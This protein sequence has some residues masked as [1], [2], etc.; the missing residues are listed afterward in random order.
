MEMLPNCEPPANLFRTAIADVFRG[1][2]FLSFYISYSLVCFLFPQKQRIRNRCRILITGHFYSRNW[3]D[4]KL[5]PLSHS[6]EV[7]RVFLISEM[8]PSP[9]NK[10]FHI[11]PFCFY[12]KW[13]GPTVGR[14]LTLIHLSIRLKPDF[15][16]GFHIMINALVSGLIARCIGARSIYFCGGGMREIA[17]GGVEG[18][19]LMEFLKVSKSNMAEGLLLK[20]VGFQDLII[21]RGDKA[22]EFFLNHAVTSQI[23]VMPSG[24]KHEI[25]TLQPPVDLH[26]DLVTVGQINKVKRHDIFLKVIHLLKTDFPKLQA[27]LIGDGECMD[28]LKEMT[29]QLGI[30]SNVRFVGNQNDIFEWLR[31]SHVFILTSDSEGLSQ[32]M[33]EAMVCGLPVV[34]SDV[35]EL[36]SVVEDG[37]NGF[38]IQ[39]QDLERY[40]HCVTT[41]LK[42]ET[43]R[44][45]AGQEAA[46]IDAREGLLAAVSTWNHIFQSY[47]TL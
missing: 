33:I 39:N 5:R 40:V 3:I 31:K 37:I 8:A 10:V 47:K 43:F 12:K 16:G 27:V 14:F 1:F 38:L 45:G 18:S 41:L 34:V 4:N 30:E 13:F 2:L 24:V 23:V 15:V 7:S 29:I 17:G 11:R 20:L 42:D 26:C 25:P 46:K 6:K 19:R 36:S 32:A 21:V 28:E 35:G 9:M 44:L 22:K